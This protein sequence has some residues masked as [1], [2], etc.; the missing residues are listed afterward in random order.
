VGALVPAVTGTAGTGSSLPPLRPRTTDRYE[1]LPM[2]TFMVPTRGG[3]VYVEVIR[4]D[5]PAGTQVPVIL[6]YTPYQLF[7]ESADDG[8]AGFFV[9]KGYA[10]ALAHVEG[11]AT[12]AGAGTTGAI[13]S[14]TPPTTWWSGWAPGPGR[15]AGW[16]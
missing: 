1:P 12:P 5:V 16:G 14:G 15:A 7:L 11:P 10:R 6:T 8:T 3:D 13:G 4:P 9:P 2:E